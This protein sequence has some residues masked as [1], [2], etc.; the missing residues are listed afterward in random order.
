MC[1]LFGKQAVGVDIADRSIEVAEIKGRGAILKVVSLGRVELES[2]IVENGRL[3]DTDRLGATLLTL[4]KNAKPKSIRAKRIVFALPESQV[5]LDNFVLH[6]D[7]ERKLPEQIKEELLHNIPLEAGELSYSYRILKEE[8]N[9]VEV[10]AAAA[11]KTVI[12]EWLEFF[13][14]NK[15]EVEILDVEILAS[16]RDL[17]RNLPKD[18]VVVL[19]LGA[20]TSYLAVFDYQGLHHEYTIHIAG[21]DFNAAIV[22]ATG[23]KEEKAEEE[24]VKAGLKSKNKKV[25]E[26]LRERLALIIEAIKQTL[27]LYHQQGGLQVSKLFLVGGSSQLIGLS[28]YFA[29][30][31]TLEVQLGEAKSVDRQVPL[32]FIEAIGLARRI[33]EKTWEHTD[34]SLPIN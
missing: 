21:E 4:F 9:S 2:G 16:F 33:L 1:N 23:W 26:A 18:P 3:K 20:H 29:K 11:S 31:L 28:E 6:K 7:K 30:E 17:C 8:K 12:Q 32:E 19:D 27:T 24:K 10:L 25:V 5:F 13:R 22:Q 14:K 15:L 34:P